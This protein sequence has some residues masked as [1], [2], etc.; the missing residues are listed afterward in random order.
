M[1]FCADLELKA[2]KSLT[3]FNLAHRAYETVHFTR[4]PAQNSV[5]NTRFLRFEAQADPIQGAFKEAWLHGEKDASRIK[6]GN[7]S[8]AGQRTAPAWRSAKGRL[9]A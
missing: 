8:L 4:K 1:L 7:E 6:A 3:R 2:Q 9:R 5:V